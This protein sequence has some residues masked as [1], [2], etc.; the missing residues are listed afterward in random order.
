MFVMKLCNSTFYCMIKRYNLKKVITSF[1][2]GIV[3]MNGTSFVR[4][5]LGVRDGALLH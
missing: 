1:Y 3:C 2:F 4:L 5:P